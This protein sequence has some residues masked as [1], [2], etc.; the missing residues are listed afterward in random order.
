MSNDDGNKGPL[1]A[2]GVLLGIG[3]GGFADG[4]V[5]HQLLQWHHMLSS[6]VDANDL[7]G[8]KYNMVWDGLFHVLTWVMTA[9]GL[10]LLWRAVKQ[11][12]APWSTR[13]LVGS[14]LLGAG[15]FDFVEGLVDHQ[16]LGLHHVHPGEGEL[17]WDAGYLAL[18]LLLMMIGRAM[19]RPDREGMG[20]AP[21][22]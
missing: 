14:L 15:L 10:G 20:G 19:I 3:L 13:Q 6:R 9:A 18:G 21:A 1:L 8:L 17:A 16:I 22:R 7:V 12:R 2:A 11:G 5:L 4:I